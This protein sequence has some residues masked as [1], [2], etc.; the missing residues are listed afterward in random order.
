MLQ[1][2]FLLFLRAGIQK[3]EGKQQSG[4]ASHQ[5]RLPGDVFV[6]K[7]IRKNAP[8]HAS[9]KEN[10]NHGKS[11]ELLLPPEQSTKKM[12]SGQGIHHATGADMRAVAAGKQPHPESGQQVGQN[13]DAEGIAVIEI[14]QSGGQHKQRHTVRNQ[15]IPIAMDKR[16]G[17]NS[18]QAFRLQRNHTKK[19]QM[20]S[21]RNFH[22]FNYPHG[23]HQNKRIN[24]AAD[25]LTLFVFTAQ[26][27]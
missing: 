15:V 13:Q 6:R 12:K 8:H 4:D 5:V 27:C 23:H 20:I 21:S 2:L 7:E 18:R 24:H 22:D 1:P 16:G 17:K 11:Q 10:N 3:K 25:K 9:V 19:R 26:N 14:K